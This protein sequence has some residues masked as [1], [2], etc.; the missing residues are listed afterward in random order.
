MAS[1][2]LNQ[3]VKK[4]DDNLI[5]NRLTME[6]KEKE[7]LAILG[8]SGAGKTTILKMIAGI[9]EV[10]GGS[11]FF[12]ERDYTRTSPQDRDLSM[13]FE[14]YALYPH[15]SVRENISFPLKSP[16]KKG[17]FS[18]SE[19]EKRV[20][21]AAKMVGLDDK[22]ERRTDQLSGGQRQRVS[23][24]RALVKKTSV[25]LMDE[26]LAH[27]DAKLRVQMRGELKRIHQDLGATI[28]YV[29]H[30]YIEA[31]AMADR[32]AV[33]NNGE[34][35]QI[36]TPEEIYFQPRNEFVAT[37]VGE[38]PMNIFQAELAAR[39][40]KVYGSW[41]GQTFEVPLPGSFSGKAVDIGIRPNN[42]NLVPAGSDNS[43]AAIVDD[44]EP[45]GRQQ[46]VTVQVGGRMLVVKS[47]RDRS[48]TLGQTVHLQFD[49][50]Y[51]HLF[52]TVTKERM[53]L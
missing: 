51:L 44:V 15:L 41:E 2:R 26:P 48:I 46:I 36:G 8:P 11:V 25:I 49:Y 24:A 5:I 42:I 34:L 7:F 3:V 27:L 28:I 22:L 43:L 30:D 13:V 1:I 4:Y 23:L 53:V 21:E 40:G 50:A 9:E 39:D 33:T 19:I 37:I 6:C 14:N 29:T 12:G 38:P 20:Q 17:Q 52:D 32:I 31:M 35:Q 16:K 45:L 18:A 47:D 10:T